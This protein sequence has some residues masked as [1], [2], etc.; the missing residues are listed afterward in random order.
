MT[1]LQHTDDLLVV[2]AGTRIVNETTLTLD[3]AHGIARVERA[4]FM[5][6]LKS[7]EVPLSEI[8]DIDLKAQ[9]DSASGAE[10][11]LPVIRL[12]SGRVLALPPIDDRAEAERTTR[13]MREFVGLQH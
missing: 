12:G 1:I 2:Q 4:T 13:E 5:I 6:P 7:E 10:R 11:F 3:R 9:T 8:R